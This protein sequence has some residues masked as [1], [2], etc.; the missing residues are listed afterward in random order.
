MTHLHQNKILHASLC[1]RAVWIGDSSLNNVKVGSYGLA[2]LNRSAKSGDCR[3][4]YAPEIFVEGASAFTFQS[5]SWAFGM[6]LLEAFTKTEPYPSLTIEELPNAF[7]TGLKPLPP[8]QM[9]LP[10]Q[11]IFKK[12]TNFR[13]NQRP[14]FLELASTL[15]QLSL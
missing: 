3:K 2:T 10:L 4:F 15:S 11:D 1:G 7:K 13:S 14:I 12:C 9:P 8:P 5:D 6:V